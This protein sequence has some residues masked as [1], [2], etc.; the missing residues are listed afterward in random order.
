MKSLLRLLLMA[1]LG[2]SFLG[3]DAQAQ[4]AWYDKFKIK[5]KKGL[6]L[7]AGDEF[8]MKFRARGQFRLEMEDSD[9]NNTTNFSVPRLR[10]KWNG[11]AYQP[12][13]L[14]TVQ[15]NTP[16]TLDM[17]DM[18]F[19]VARNNSFIPRIGQWK[20]PF[21]RQEL[22]SSS[23]L[24]FINR[25]IVNS[26]FGLGRD[27]GAAI[28]GGFGPMNNFS[29]SFGAFNGAGKND[30]AGQGDISEMLYAGRVQFGYGGKGDKFKAGSSY[31]TGSAYSIKPNFAKA[32]TFVVGIGGAMMS[33]FNCGVR[34]PDGKGHCK[35]LTALDF[36]DKTGA[37]GDKVDLRLI[38]ADA[39]FK[40]PIFNV[41]G[42]Y[43][44]R[45][46][47]P[48]SGPKKD[49]GEAYD[50]G[51]NVQAGA[52]IVPKKLEVTGRYSLIDYDTKVKDLELAEGGDDKKWTIS[53][54]VNYYLSGDHRWKIQAEYLRTTNEYTGAK[55]DKEENTFALQLQAYF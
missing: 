5:Y 42:S 2:L 19:T 4:D 44:G 54:A 13:F 45:W 36:S 25:S 8:K 51:Y 12:W 28:M 55:K 27:L 20:V 50:S 3:A 29:Y 43:Y 34:T 37:E 26:E 48:Q 7:Q 47:D 6:T 17:R 35:R 11:Y 49:V 22:T 15:I 18:Y 53:S 40:M 14:Y 39:S 16:K 23:A 21:N 10:F 46:I 9:D 32:H 1:M 24:Q 33:D 38:T 30:S 52:F 41:Q 31:A